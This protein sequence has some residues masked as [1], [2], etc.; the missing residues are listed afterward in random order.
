MSNDANECSMSGTNAVC[1]EQSRMLTDGNKCRMSNVASKCRISP[2]NVE[3]R[4][5]QANV[6]WCMSRSIAV[7]RERMLNYWS[8]SQILFHDIYSH[9]GNIH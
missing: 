3:L 4:V 7:R 2:V 8:K 1:Q 6:E 5:S 9:D